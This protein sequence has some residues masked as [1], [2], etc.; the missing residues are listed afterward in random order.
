MPSNRI[1]VGGRI[2]IPA[3]FR[4][5]LEL[6]PGTLVSWREVNGR[7]ELVAFNRLL[8]QIRGSLKSRPGE[9]SAFDL[10]FEE[11]KRERMREE[12]KFR[13]LTAKS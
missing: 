3:K 11:R 7:L 1:G 2:T 6:R 4:K 13:K 12:S 5:K 9:P 8:K 10:L